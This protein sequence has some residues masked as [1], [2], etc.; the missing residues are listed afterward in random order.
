VVY[1][2]EKTHLIVIAFLKSNDDCSDDETPQ[3]KVTISKSFY[4]GKYEVAQEQWVKIMGSDPSK[5]TVRTKP[6]ETVSWNDAQKFIEKLNSKEGKK[7]RLL[8]SCWSR[9]L[10]GLAA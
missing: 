8:S 4:M 10:S 2:Y 1:L 3:H 9:L 5:F 6:V 7:Y